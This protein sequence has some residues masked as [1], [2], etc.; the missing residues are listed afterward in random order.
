MRWKRRCARRWC[1]GSSVP[2]ASGRS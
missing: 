1:S 2:A